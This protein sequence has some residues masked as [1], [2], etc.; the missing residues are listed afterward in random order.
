M[1]SPVREYVHACRLTLLLVARGRQ[2]VRTSNFDRRSTSLPSPIE[3]EVGHSISE[4]YWHVH[5][6]SGG[7]N[8]GCTC[9]DTCLGNRSRV[10]AGLAPGAQGASC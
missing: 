7:S 2:G 10:A 9:A 8:L 5:L 3:F 4:Y 6:R 1:L